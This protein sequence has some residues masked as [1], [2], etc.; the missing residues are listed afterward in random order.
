MRELVAYM[1]NWLLLI[2]ASMMGTAQAADPYLVG[3]ITDWHGCPLPGVKVT[4]SDTS[5][6]SQVSGTT[7]G[8]G[9]YAIRDV[10]RGNV[11]VRAEL[12]GFRSVTAEPALYA[13]RNVWDAGLPLQLLVVTKSHSITGA[14]RANDGS[15]I[16]DASVTLWNVF[17]PTRISQTR[18]D[19]QGRFSVQTV[20]SG[21]FI[22][23][24]VSPN[25]LAATHI[26][27][28]EQADGSDV[29]IDFVLQQTEYCKPP[30]TSLK[31]PACLPKTDPAV[32]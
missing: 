24:A 30:R 28:F 17:S 5:G 14:V 3:R 7:D 18:S 8:S 21:Q 26:A 1:S 16:A 15:A 25:F 31:A 19:K 4:I 20:D 13:G 22:I 27:N 11:V 12:A 6:R 2:I 9:H 10:P 29:V 23:S 32:M